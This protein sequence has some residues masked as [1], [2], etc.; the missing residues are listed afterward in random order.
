MDFFYSVLALRDDRGHSVVERLA[1]GE[2]QIVCLGDGFHAEGRAA[3]RWREA[4][5]EFQAGY[6]RRRHMDVEMRESLGVME[7]V[8][9]TKLRYP[10]YFHFLKGNHENVTN[11]NGDG[12][13]S[14]RKYAQ[15]G[16]MVLVYLKSFYGE[17]V[18]NALYRFEKLL[19]LLAVGGCFLASH[20]EPATLVDREALLA[21]R[22][23]PE[24][25][26]AL[27]WTDNGEAEAGSVDAML[28]H[29]LGENPCESRYY[30]GGHRPVQDSYGLRAGGRYV[31]IH[32]PERFVIAC[33]PGGGDFDLDRDI[34]EIE[35]LEPGEIPDAEEE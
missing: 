28:D 24:V 18:L 29:Y 6:R 20:A 27:T 5:K 33:L 10:D 8:M 23:V 35:T 30:F 2:L 26:Y 1:G 31:Q 15:E 7:M 19:P 16:L 9:E 12:N 14:F 22:S 25:V 32:D 17:E 34:I 21:Y 11:E 3:R 13:Y 4:L